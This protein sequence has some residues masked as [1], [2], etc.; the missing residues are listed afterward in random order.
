MAMKAATASLQAQA[1][2]RRQRIVRAWTLTGLVLVLGLAALSASAQGVYRIVGPDG[3][4]TFSDQ[5]PATADARPA[6]SGTSAAGTSGGVQLPFQLRQV[7]GRYP[8]TLYTSSDCAPCNSGRNLLNA[9]GI[10]YSEKLINTAEDGEALKRLSGDMTLP[11]LTIGAQQIKGYSDAEWTQF[12]DA[13]GYPKTSA[14]P[15]TYR[16]PAPAPL[17]ATRAPAAPAV[18][19]DRAA[20]RPAAP[21]EV[22]V[23]PPVNN[24]AGIR[25]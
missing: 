6:S 9:R 12:L 18:A 24:P 22:P 23:T 21:A 5:P 13:A 7:A 1:D 3:R 10:P 8:V 19:G 4:V 14:L 20:A 17:V 15:S 16:R 25:F 2:A 11:F